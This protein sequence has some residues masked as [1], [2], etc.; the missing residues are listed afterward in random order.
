MPQHAKRG[1]VV[2]LFDIKAVYGIFSEV[3][4]SIWQSVHFFG[5][6]ECMNYL[7]IVFIAFLLAFVIVYYLTNKKYRYVVIFLG[8]YFFY[9]FANPKMLLI[10][11]WVT[12]ISYVGGLMLGKKKSKAVLCLFFFL[13]IATLLVYKYT[14]FAI[15]NIN[16]L[17]SRFIGKSIDVNW[18]VALPVGLSFMVFQA[19]TYLSEIY[20]D[21]TE[22]EKN[23]FRYAAFVSFFPTILSGPI[24]KAK[25]LLPQ[26]KSPSEFDVQMGKKGT[27][28]FLW[29]LFEKIMVANKLNVIYLNTIPDYQ[30]YYSADILI[31]AVAF[32]LYIYADFSSYSDMARGVSMI[33]GIEIGKNFNNPYLSCSTAEFWSRWHV[34]LNE[35]FIENVYIPLGGNRKGIVRKYFNMMIVFLISGLWHGANWHFIMWGAINGA[36]V[37]IG[38]VVKPVKDRIYEK[39]NIDQSVESVV[40]FK[41]IIVFYLITLTWV[42]FSSGITDSLRICKRIVLFNYLSIFNSNLLNIAGTA[43]ETFITV[44][45]TFVFCKI[46]VKRQNEKILYEKYD[47]QPFF[48]QSL[49]PA[50]LICICIFGACSTN[51]SVDTRFLYFQF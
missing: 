15:T 40:L 50:L 44:T 24:Q 45:S 6:Y 26:I 48:F 39:F 14:N 8:S 11:A 16:Y 32:S 43:I 21:Q 29:G 37:I 34:S 20:R 41:R 23:L 38:L 47:R 1:L 35:W 5:G 30:S 10:L 3:G 33:L 2:V 51:A 25:N 4:F 13:E 31:G 17:A 12:L 18:D 22:I 36:F 42:F 46:Q 49:V 19:C 9:G 28:L 27:L 7:S